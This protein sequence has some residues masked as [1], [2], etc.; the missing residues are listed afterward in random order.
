M[1]DLS[2]E[3]EAPGSGVEVLG[4][5]RGKKNLTK[6]RREKAKNDV[7]AESKVVVDVDETVDYGN[8]G[9]VSRFILN[10]EAEDAGEDYQSGDSYDRKFFSDS[11]GDVNEECETL[12]D[13]D[14][15]LTPPGPRVRRPRAAATKAA[16][17]VPVDV[18][19]E[20]IEIEGSSEEEE[21][22][23]PQTRRGRQMQEQRAMDDRFAAL[24]K[25]GSDKENHGNAVEALDVFLDAVDVNTSNKAL[26]ME[27]HKKIAK[28]SDRL[29]WLNEKE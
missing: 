19:V 2:K 17:K 7:K 14:L 18:D 12:G 25:M 27:L 28:L 4:R 15:D 11:D 21:A 6:S 9:D 22:F 26:K 20:V 24:F 23:V 10:D 1:I 8:V 3:I 5:G 29:G 13:S 16:A